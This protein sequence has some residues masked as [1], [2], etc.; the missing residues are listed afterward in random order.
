MARAGFKNLIG[1][2]IRLR[3]LGDDELLALIR[4]IT[5]LYAQYYNWAVRITDEEQLRF[6][7]LCLSRAGAVSAP[8]I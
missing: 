4:R 2:V 1:P 5:Q 3:R 6:L 7:E 8:A